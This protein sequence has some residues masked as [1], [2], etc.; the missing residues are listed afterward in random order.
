[1]LIAHH[2]CYGGHGCLLRA[3]PTNFEFLSSSK[4]QTFKLSSCHGCVIL[5]I[6]ELIDVTVK[7]SKTFWIKGVKCETKKLKRVVWPLHWPPQ[8]QEVVYVSIY[9]IYI[10]DTKA[11]LATATVE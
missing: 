11:R 10:V 9:G 3:N 7:C 4:T 6:F 1:M 8:T 5:V 2:V